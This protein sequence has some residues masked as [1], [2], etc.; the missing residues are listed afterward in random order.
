MALTKYLNYIPFDGARGF[1][2]KF[3]YWQESKVYWMEIGEETGGSESFPQ[4]KF[5]RPRPPE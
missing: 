1:H 2:Y 3:E 4:K 5:S